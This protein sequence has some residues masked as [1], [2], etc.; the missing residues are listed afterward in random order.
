MS[1][2]NL[3]GSEESSRSCWHVVPLFVFAFFLSTTLSQLCA[4]NL[5]QPDNNRELKVNVFIHGTIGIE[6]APLSFVK[7]KRDNIEDSNYVKQQSRLRNSDWLG[8][9]S[10]MFGQGLTEINLDDYT[11]PKA[12][13]FQGAYPIVHAFRHVQNLVEGTSPNKYYAFGWTGLL[14]NKARILAA[15]QM[16]VA[17]QKLD[18]DLKQAG[19]S[20][21][22]NLIAHSHG[23]NC[24]LNMVKVRMLREALRNNQTDGLEPNLLTLGQPF[25]QELLNYEPLF[26]SAATLLCTPIQVEN[27]KLA[28]DQMFG[29]IFNFYSLGDKVQTGDYFSSQDRS[30]RMLP[31]QPGYEKFVQ[32]EVLAEEMALGSTPLKPARLITYSPTHKEFWSLV[33]TEYVKDKKNH[34]NFIRPLP[35]L[36]LVPFM[37]NIL[38]VDKPNF[39]GILR[40]KIPTFVRPRFLQIRLR[41]GPNQFKNT[42]D[43]FLAFTVTDAL[44]GELWDNKRMPLADFSAERRATHY[45]FD[46]L[47][48]QMKLRNLAIWKTWQT[49]SKQNS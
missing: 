25:A 14:S 34:L 45:F 24:I 23:G 5:N 33:S 9:S 21:R 1:Q 41:K 11:S 15:F 19:W 13:N 6:A 4:N 36:V 18:S 31:D 16:Y 27:S 30:R 38:L 48:N 44:S 43:D 35:L 37:Q 7:I 28:G 12:V 26:I 46:Q 8:K 17:L 10:I 2:F 40:P 42:P 47:R 49:F 39:I 20:P 32:C 3:S 29:R 22:F